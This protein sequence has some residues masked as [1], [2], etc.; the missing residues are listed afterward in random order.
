MSEKEILL[1][2]NGN[3]EKVSNRWDEIAKQYA[4]KVIAVEN[5]EVIGDAKTSTE[6]IKT[7]ENQKKDISS[8]LIISVPPP[9]VAYIL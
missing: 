9:N 3:G 4:G 8:I 2:A 7:L 6:L 5:G 1:K